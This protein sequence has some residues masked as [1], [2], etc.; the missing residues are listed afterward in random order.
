MAGFWRV[1]FANF[2]ISLILVSLCSRAHTFLWRK[3]FTPFFVFFF[4]GE[5]EDDEV[6]LDFFWVRGGTH[7]VPTSGGT[8]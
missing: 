6:I 1:D 5:H 4:G 2:T 8:G 3:V 7:K